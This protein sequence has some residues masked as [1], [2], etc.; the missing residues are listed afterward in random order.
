MRYGSTVVLILFLTIGTLFAVDLQDESYYYYEGSTISLQV[1]PDRISVVFTEKTPVANYAS[2]LEQVLG[3]DLKSTQ[4]K[5][6]P[7]SR[8]VRL[9]GRFSVSELERVLER[10]LDRPETVSAAP[11]FIQKGSGVHFTIDQKC[12]VRFTDTANEAE[13]QAFVLEN[14]IERLKKI[15]PRTYLCF[16]PPNSGLNGISAANLFYDDPLTL[17]AEPNFIYLNGEILNAS[18]NDTYWPQQ[19]AHK[20]TGQQVSS[21]AGDSGF[22]ATVNG[23]EDA[24]MDV[25][26]AWDYLASNGSQAGGSASVLVALLDSG[27][28]LDHPDIQGNLF[29]AGKDFTTDGQSDANDTQGHGTCTAGIVAAVGNNGLGVAG[30]AYNSKILPVRIMNKWGVTSTDNLVLAFDYAWQQGADVISNSWTGTSPQSALTEAIQRAKTQGRE[31]LGCV[32]VFSSGNKGKGTVEYPADLSET[33]A[34]GAS[35]MF[36]EKKNSGSGDYNRKWSSNYGTALDLAAPTIVYTTDIQG[37][38]GYADGDYFDHFGGTSAACPNAAGVAALVL[39]ANSAL[40]SDEV[41][42]VLQNS[43]DKI[44]RYDYDNSGWNKHVG[45]GRVNALNAVQ[46]AAGNDGNPPLAVHQ[47]PASIRSI[48]PRT[49][50]FDISD[51]NGL[52]GGADEPRLYFR[53]ILNS[54]TSAWAS[55]TDTDGPAGDTYEFSIP[56]QKWSTEVQYYLYVKDNSLQGKNQ[57]YPFGGNTNAAPNQLYLYHVGNFSTQT[58]SQNAP[59]G[60]ENNYQDYHTSTLN[61]SD[62]YKIV[63]VNATLNYTGNLDEVGID[64]SGPDDRGAGLAMHYEGSGLSN[65]TFDDEAALTI[66]DGSDPFAGSYQADNGLFTFDGKKTAGAWKIGVYDGDYTGSNDG[67]VDNWNLDVTYM[68]PDAAPV[69]DDIPAQ[70]VPEGGSFSTINLDDY[71]TDADHPDDSLSWTY[72]GNQDL[73]VSIN[74]SR[75][76]TVTIPDENWYG[77]EVITFTA[78][79]PGGYSDSD[80]VLFTVSAVNDPPVVTQIPDQTIE[81]G[82][83]FSTIPLDEYVSDIDNTDSEISWETSGNQELTVAID[84]NHVATILIPNVD[85]NG[86]ETITFKASDPGA[87]SDSTEAVFTVTAVNDAPRITSQADSSALEDQLYQY[88]VV[89]EDVDEGALLSYALLTAPAFL[90]ISDSGLIS[91]TPTNSDVGAHDVSV[92]VKDQ[93]NAADTQNYVLTVDNQN[94]PPVVSD[95]PDQTIDEGQTFTTISLDDYV[96]DPDNGDSEMNWS[97]SGNQQLTVQIDGN[98]IAT[99]SVPDSNWNGQE[100]ITFKASDPGALADSNA[101]LFTVNAVND[102]PQIVNL[103]DS[104]R[105]KNSQQDTLQMADY[106]SDIDSPDDALQWFFETADSSLKTDYNADRNELILST[107]GFKGY[108]NLFLTLSDD[109]AAVAHDTLLVHVLQDETTLEPNGSL[110][111]EQVQLFQN[112]PNPF[113]PV[114]VID[115]RLPAA[116][117]VE[118]AVYNILGEK[119]R[120]LVKANQQAGSYSVAFD[121]RNLP[122]GVY[123]YLLRTASGASVIK[124]MILLK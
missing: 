23:Y 59:S 35:N 58:Y 36:D 17:W 107:E 109:S 76:A 99:V 29:S 110:A 80:T 61:I 52:A 33:I 103:P 74:T 83:S 111:P 15:A 1:V 43:A 47:W 85:W 64:L 16:I 108:V 54:D 87:L 45:Y 25:D 63:D 6:S 86:Q 26:L 91:G 27:V 114:T 97:V 4:E 92:Q 112:Y 68:V 42:Q 41:Q 55:V 38:A 120:V 82:E 19:W 3:T 115:Y 93:F 100:I 9:R 12:I 7:R 106:Q 5:I 70:T 44:E 11:V 75:Q 37:T 53:T 104:I 51:E 60:W 8:L 102:A 90:S 73:T 78:T 88:Q 28:D 56:G 116:K 69:V 123:Y 81:E 118:L 98:R 48:E 50:R 95:I 30:I 10:I 31:G 79:D 121:G 101:A 84:Q 71:V 117:R 22:P 49:I 66:T 2:V 67:S 65:T 21:G 14:K 13:I 96:S 40:S 20:N 72:S 46:S 94:D 89:A 18:V 39:A 32:I 113:N 34:V 122:S 62:D 124:K 24:D 119:V 57:T 105:F 77:S